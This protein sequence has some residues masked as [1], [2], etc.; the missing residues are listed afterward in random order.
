MHASHKI[1]PERNTYK[2]ILKKK[3][4]ALKNLELYTKK[5]KKLPLC[6][7]QIYMIKSPPPPL[8]LYY[9]FQLMFIDVYHCWIHFFEALHCI[10]LLYNL[11]IDRKMLK[12]RQTVFFYARLLINRVFFFRIFFFSTFGNSR[13]SIVLLLSFFFKPILNNL[14]I[15]YYVNKKIH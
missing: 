5:K 10:F 15:C 14:Y 13:V 12:S 7:G 6:G 3:R 1:I 11:P 4:K 9:L 8:P 2:H